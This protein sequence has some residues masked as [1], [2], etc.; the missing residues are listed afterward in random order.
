MRLDR[1]LQKEGLREDL[2][3]DLCLRLEFGVHP[4]HT[5]GFCKRLNMGTDLLRRLISLPEKKWRLG[6]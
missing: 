1:D 3:N 6:R 2:Q 5:A 4:K